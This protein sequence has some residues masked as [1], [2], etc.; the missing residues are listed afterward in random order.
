METEDSLAVSV[1]APAAKNSSDFPEVDCLITMPAVYQP[2]PVPDLSNNDKLMTLYLPDNMRQRIVKALATLHTRYLGDLFPAYAA[3]TLKLIPGKFMTVLKLF[4]R[5]S[6]R[7]L[8]LCHI[9]GF[10]ISYFGTSLTYYFKK[11]EK[12]VYKIGSISLMI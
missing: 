12:A 6:S 4:I 7:T 1:I 8:V 10:N 5:P 9:Y 11:M 3:F 2:V